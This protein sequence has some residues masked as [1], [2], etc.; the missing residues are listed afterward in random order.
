MFD[1][2]RFLRHARAQWAEQWRTWAWFLAIG[3]I[4][5]CVLLLLVLF[6]GDRG[7]RA[8]S[9]DM[10]AGLFVTGFIVTAPIFAARYF[11][12]MA[13]PE[14]EGVLLMRPVSAFEKWLLALVV[15]V[16][17]YPLAYALAFQVGNVPAALYAGLQVAADVAADPKDVPINALREP[18]TF[19]PILPW[20]A[21]DSAR[22][23]L[24]TFLTVAAWQGFAV[25]G[26]LYFRRMPFVKTVVAGF[27]LLLVL[28]FLGLLFESHSAIFLSWWA[29]EGLASSLPLSHRIL[30]PLAWWLVPGLL[31]LAALF[32]LREREVA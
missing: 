1:P 23:A 14:S 8:Y 3:I 4:V 30:V 16:L 31:W 32:A 17:A 19:S 5:H 7:Y 10:Q 2:A 11:Q 21:F 6:A 13:R 18:A 29:R 15:V 24:G 28:I 27:V 12:A 22:S 20:Q 9:H 25:T 26:C